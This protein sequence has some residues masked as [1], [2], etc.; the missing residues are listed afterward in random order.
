MTISLGPTRLALPLP[1]AAEALGPSQPTSTSI[2]T[3]TLGQQVREQLY[4]WQKEKEQ[5]RPTTDI[6]RASISN[7]ISCRVMKVLLPVNR[8][9]MPAP[10]Q[11][12]LVKEVIGIAMGLDGLELTGDGGLW[13]ISWHASDCTNTCLCDIFGPLF[14]P[15]LIHVRR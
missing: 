8:P 7:S 4:R 1:T 14:K 11:R 10:S 9:T 2:S 15:S 5:D 12:Y 3:S 13:A 6:L